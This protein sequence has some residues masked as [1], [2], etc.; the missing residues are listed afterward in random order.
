[1]VNTWFPFG[2]S[3]LSVYQEVI[4]IKHSK[5]L[6]LS[7]LGKLIIAKTSRETDDYHFLV[8]W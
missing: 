6:G 4:I 5:E 3:R 2:L 8:N 1:L 7:P